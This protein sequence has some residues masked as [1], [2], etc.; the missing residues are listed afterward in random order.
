M[1]II[2]IGGS[3]LIGL[4]MVIILYFVISTPLEIIFDAFDDADTADATDDMN[5]YLPYIRNAMSMAFAVAIA[6]PLVIFVMRTFEREPRYDYR[7]L[8]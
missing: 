5:I 2:R 4:F 1:N 7:R 8:R 6:A 3:L